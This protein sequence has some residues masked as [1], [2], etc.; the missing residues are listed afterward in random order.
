MLLFGHKFKGRYLLLK[1]SFCKD[2]Y[3][4]LVG[5]TLA[6][7][8]VSDITNPKFTYTPPLGT[9]AVV[10]EHICESAQILKAIYRLS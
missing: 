9:R 8:R 2:Y 3:K 5:T 6:S 7:S 4:R 1:K 10:V